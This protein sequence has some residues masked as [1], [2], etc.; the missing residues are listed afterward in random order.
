MGGGAV[1]NLTS[2]DGDG[3]GD[4]DGDGYG[5]GDGDG[6]G[7]DLTTK[8]LL[9]KSP[10]IFRKLKT[11]PIGLVKQNPSQKLLVAFDLVF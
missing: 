4:G 3:Y 8:S 9:M 2:G 6:Y 11:G 5:S 1:G 10:P 7:S